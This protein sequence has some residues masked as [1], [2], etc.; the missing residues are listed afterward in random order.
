MG[1]RDYFRQSYRKQVLERSEGKLGEPLYLLGF[2][3]GSD[4]KQSASNAG[5]RGLIL[6]SGRSLER[7]MA[8]HC[9]ILA[10]RTPWEE[11]RSRGLQRVGH[12]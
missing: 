3:G 4:G 11:L 7:G 8:T 9:S 12:G 5:D 1:G 10:W 6:G 2:P